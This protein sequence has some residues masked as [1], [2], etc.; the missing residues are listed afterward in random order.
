MATNRT[1]HMNMPVP[2]TSQPGPAYAQNISNF[3]TG[4]LYILGEHTHDGVNSGQLIN[5]S[6]Q[7]VNQDLSLDG[8]NLSDTRAV[9]LNNQS[10]TLT[11]TNDVNEFYVYDGN[12]Y[13]NNAAGF[14]IALTNGDSALT[15]PFNNFTGVNVTNTNLTIPSTAGYNLLNVSTT[16]S[17][18]NI[19]LPLAAAVTAGRFFVIQ[20]VGN[21]VFG[22]ISSKSIIVQVPSGSGNEIYYAGTGSSSYQ[23]T[24]NGQSTILVSD[25][26][27][28]WHT[29]NFLKNNFV[30]D[31]LTY[32][33][34]SMNIAESTIAMESTAITMD[35]YSSL[36][37]DGYFQWNSPT[38][39]FS[40]TASATE[41]VGNTAINGSL[42]VTGA[43]IVEGNTSLLGTGNTVV[44]GTITGNN[45]PFNLGIQNVTLAT[46]MTLSPAQCA[47]PIIY[48]QSGALSGNVTL[49][50]NT[51]APGIWFIIVGFVT[52]NSHHIL[53]QNSVGGPNFTITPSGTPEE[54]E[55][56]TVISTGDGTALWTS[57]TEIV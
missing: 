7:Y 33:S 36:I 37:G 30:F 5:I 8:Y 26:S 27:A 49:T 10:S 21:N 23:F 19:T 13:F 16:S 24:S 53:I 15:V 32:T 18:A 31:A 48:L 40:V 17:A 11:G 56:L 25:G 52:F 6:G 50:L 47:N 29:F 35:G 34:V 22:N 42:G 45:L 43:L 9:R 41:I 3:P 1:P 28:N 57:D 46:T 55:I 2:D 12:A 38:Q 20:D 54:T 44:G 51:G 4:C 39:V 14:P